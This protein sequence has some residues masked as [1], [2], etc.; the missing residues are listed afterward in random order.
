MSRA[1]EIIK[2]AERRGVRTRWLLS[3]PSL[4]ISFFA[5]VGPLAVV[6]L[7]SFIVKGDYV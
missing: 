3:A 5:A 1:R 6:V 7:Y 4:L 2:A